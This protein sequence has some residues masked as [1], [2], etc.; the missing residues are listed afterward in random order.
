MMSNWNNTDGY[1]HH[2]IIISAYSSS[3]LELGL[4]IAHFIHSEVENS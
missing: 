3:G 4:F 2:L 1:I